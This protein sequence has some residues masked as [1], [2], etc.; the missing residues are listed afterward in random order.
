MQIMKC[1]I[2]SSNT[3][4]IFNLK[5]SRTGKENPLYFCT[6]CTSFFQRP[7]YHE[8]DET[9]RRDLQW[10]LSKHEEH[11][12]QAKQ[13]IHQLLVYN[14]EIKTILD[15]GSGIGS[16]ILAARELGINCIG[17]EP[18][19]Y[20]VQYS[21]ENLSLDLIPDYFSASLFQEG[22]DAIV[23]DMVLEHVPM[24]QPFMKD[25]FSIL[26]PGGVIFLAVPG[27][28]W[29]ISRNILRILLKRIDIV[30]VFGDNDVHINHF[31]RRGVNNLIKPY[32]GKIL[33]DTYPGACIIKR[34]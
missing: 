20:A 33:K 34:S 12:K 16:T 15:I 10:H 3:L 7:N 14:P 8:D 31:S 29:S 21:K 1:P 26:N 23:I 25:V 27:L 6:K 4:R 24:V 5:G 19:P 32:D 17:V 11:K 18:N 30:S 28:N 9:L 22:F 2:C 13:I